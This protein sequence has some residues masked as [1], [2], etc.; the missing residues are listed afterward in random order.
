MA[1]NTYETITSTALAANAS[2]VILGSIPQQNYRDF[3]VVAEGQTSG[4]GRIRVRLN[5]DTDSSYRWIVMLGRDRTTADINLSDNEFVMTYEAVGSGHDFNCIFQAM[6]YTDETKKTPMQA[7][8]NYR[9]S[10]GFYEVDA[11]GGRWESH[12]PSEVSGVEF[13]ID[14]GAVFTAGST[15][16]LYGIAA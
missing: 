1:T 11:W 14:G 5:G 4:T 16:T 3:V 15:F 10:S 6:D 12:E 13:F 7:R 9:N 8:C 2:S